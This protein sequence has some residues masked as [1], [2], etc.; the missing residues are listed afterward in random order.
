MLQ[1]RLE[2]PMKTVIYR[3]VD[4]DIH[5]LTFDTPEADIIIFREKTAAR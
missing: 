4:G 5:D 2:S 3:G 1:Y